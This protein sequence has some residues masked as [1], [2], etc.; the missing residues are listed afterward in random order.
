MPSTLRNA[1]MQA[2]NQ[3]HPGQ[4]GMKHLAQNIWWPHINRQ[5][6]FQ[7]INIKSIISKSQ[8]SKFCSLLETNGELKLDFAGP[9]DSHW[10]TNKY[11][12]LCI[13]QFSKFPSAR[14][15]TST[16]SKTVIEFLQDYI[17]FHGK[18]YSITVE[19]HLV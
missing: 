14:S 8:I 6:Y 18:L 3:T 2:L 10:G 12:L 7:G 1:M 5:I 17:F 19:P 9:L 4:F 13:D 16:S 15:T 11:I